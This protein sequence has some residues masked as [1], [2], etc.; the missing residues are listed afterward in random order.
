MNN[1]SVITDPQTG[2]F[3]KDQRSERNA[4]ISPLEA[5]HFG[6]CVD[7]MIWTKYGSLLNGTHS[8]V[9]VRI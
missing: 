1:T 4:T 6:D 8:F 9:D 3:T 7:K 2:K 5:T